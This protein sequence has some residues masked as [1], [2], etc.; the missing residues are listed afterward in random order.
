M[1]TSAK[2]SYQKL[3]ALTWNIEGVKRNM[4]MLAEILNSR[5]CSLV[6]LSEPQA[7]QCDLNHITQYIAHKYCYMLNYEDNYEPELP[8][9]QSKA[10]GGTMVLWQ[11]WL[12]PYVK[13]VAVTT[14]AFLPIVLSI[15]GSQPTVH[16]ALYLPTHGQDTE[17]V[18]E[19]A[20]LRNCLDELNSVYDYPR[21]YI[22][23]DA[24]VNNKNVNRVNILK[25]L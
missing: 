21:I 5:S 17:F 16:V 25:A 12:D 8:L 7:Y 20:S 22:R 4:F 3:T 6:F 1:A 11:K 14:T 13:V 24:N 10:K 15:P 23:G 2:A 9:H 19:L 18:S